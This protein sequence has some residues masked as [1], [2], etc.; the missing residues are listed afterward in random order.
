MSTCWP[1]GRARGGHI[2][3]E[4][5]QRLATPPDPACMDADI[6]SLASCMVCLVRRVDRNEASS[7]CHLTE[8]VVP[9]THAVA[10]GPDPW[11]GCRP[12]RCHGCCHRCCRWSPD[13]VATEKLHIATFKGPRYRAEFCRRE[14]KKRARS[15]P[16]RRRRWTP[17]RYAHLWPRP[18]P[19]SSSSTSSA[20]SSS[21]DGRTEA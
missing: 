14:R 6:R 9:R 18:W 3:P 16:P 20:R 8:S 11:R 15:H 7:R 4:P 2:A 13:L 17:P 1:C 12:Q 5:R 21:E 19:K 10:P